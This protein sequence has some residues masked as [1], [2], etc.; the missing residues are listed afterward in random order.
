MIGKLMSKLTLKMKLGLGFG[1]LLLILMVLGVVAYDSVGQLADISDQVD[2]IMAK[3]DMASQIEAGI[4]K[5]TTAVRGFLLAPKE[6]LLKHDEEG[7]KQYIENMEK[8]GKLL[9]YE[10]AKQIFAEITS[11]YTQFRANC[12]R[13]IEL[14]RTHKTKDALAVV[15]NP[16]T[17]EIRTRLRTEIAQM[18]GFQDKLKVDVLKEQSAIEARVRWLV[19]VLGIVGTLVGLVIATLIIR[20]ITA[21]MSEMV[22]VI[23]EIAAN[24]LAVAD[25]D[26][27]V[28]DE[29]GKAGEALNRMKN[30]L[31]GIIQSIASTAEHVASASEEI[32]A[33]ATQQ[34]QSAETQKDQ[35][36]QVATAMQQMSSTVTSVSDSCNKAA[37]AARQAAETARLGGSIVDGTLTKMRVIAESVGATAKKMEELGKSSDQI[38]RIIGVIDDIADQT[39]LLALNAAIEAARAGEQ[40]RGFA[41]V[42]DEVRKLAE[43]TTTATKEIAQMIKNVQDETKVA[44][45]AMESGTQQ[46]EEGVTSTAKAGDSLRAIIQMSEQVGGMI[47]EIATAATE[48]SSTTE[49]V[50]GNVDQISRLVKESAIGA[51]QSATACHDLSG[52]ALDLQTMVG[53]FKL[54]DGFGVS[55]ARVTSEKGRSSAAARPKA[56][57][58]GTS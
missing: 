7:K 39:N 15:F 52:L 22:E 4:E 14:Q 18:S 30:N 35:T 13:E 8:L 50:N 32:S 29:S 3:K 2:K 46:V 40:G 20:S 11:N 56:F 21:T 34:A 1:S 9:S 6:E 43:R 53:K 33:S 19:I 51:Q 41:V 25:I 44:V 54:E 45:T 55:K 26:V 23:Q 17:G 12:D 38:G 48:Q 37:D 5:Q 10:E 31:R 28:R 27:T 49:Q 42:A 58:A 16:Q 47:T 24:N 57:A 36:F